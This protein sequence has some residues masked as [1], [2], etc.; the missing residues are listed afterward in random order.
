MKGQ[1]VIIDL[2]NMDFMKNEEGKIN[3]YDTMEEACT[4]CGMYEFEDAWV[5]QLMYNYKEMETTLDVYDNEMLSLNNDNNQLTAENLAET[6]INVMD[7]KGRAGCKNRTWI[8]FEN[9]NGIEIGTDIENMIKQAKQF[10]VNNKTQNDKNN[11]LFS[12]KQ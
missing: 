4:V 8:G 9:G 6:V 7:K 11:D 1:Y 3:Y 10:L 5:M 12:V 2:R